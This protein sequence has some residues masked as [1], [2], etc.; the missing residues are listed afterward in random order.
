M[1][2][3]VKATAMSRTQL[4]LVGTSLPVVAI[5]LAVASP[6]AAQERPQGFFLTT[7]L[8]LSSGYDSKFTTGPAEITDSVSIVTGPTMSWIGTTHKTEYSLSY[9]PEV[10]IFAHNPDLN[11]WN[12][13]ATMRMTHQ[14][15]SRWSLNAGDSYLDT[16]DSN[17]ALVNSLLLLPRGR[18][19]ENT[20]YTE[21]GYRLDQATRIKFRFDNTVDTAALSGEFQGRLDYLTAAGSVTVDR[22][23]TASQTL[24]GSYAFIHAMPL[25]P[26]AAG[27]PSDVHLLNAIY[28]YEINRGLLLRAAGGFVESA[29][30]AATGSIEIEKAFG[31]LWTAA[32]YQRYV[33]FFGG[34]LPAEGTPETVQFANA[35]TPSSVYEV[36]SLRGWGQLTRRIGIEAN[37]QKALNGVNNQGIPVRSLIGRMRITYRLTDRLAFFTELDHF[38]QN[39]NQ[40]SGNRLDENRF[41]GGIQVTLSRPPERENPRARHG[42]APQ[43]SRQ[44]LLPPPDEPLAGDANPDLENQTND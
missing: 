12:Q 40:F 4:R 28:T 29:Q 38:G 8:E 13:N 39:F 9:T 2:K 21:L 22:T 44:G 18:Y 41:F 36:V 37:G 16:T 1:S 30:P 42:K 43:D 15:N 33:G 26:S 24:T 27:S 3:A 6:G 10:E 11:S 32:A 17:R 25:H 5:L 23:L 7:P 19:R 35:L 31:S 20:L 34:L 14:I